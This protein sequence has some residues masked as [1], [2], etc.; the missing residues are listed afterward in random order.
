MTFVGICKDLANDGKGIVEYENKIVLVDNLLVGEK[1]EIEIYNE[2]SRCSY[3]KVVKLITKSKDRKETLCPNY[4]KCGGCQ[5]MHLDYEKQ[6][7]FK[8]EQI[9]RAYKRIANI[10]VDVLEP[11]F[12]NEFGYRNKIELPV[13]DNKIGFYKN[14]TKQIV[15]IINCKLVDNKTNDVIR[16]ISSIIKITKPDIKHIVIKRSFKL[17][18]TMLIVVSKEKEFLRKEEF[19]EKIINQIPYLTTLIHNINKNKHLTLS[20]KNVTIFGK[21]YIEDEIL[22]TKFIVS[23][24]SFYQV[25]AF[26]TET[27]YA[28]AIEQAKISK[29]DVVLDA[30]CGVGTIGILASK[31]AK[32]VY[33]VEINIE[34][35]KDARK[36]AKLNKIDN[37]RFVCNDAKKFLKSEA[38]DANILILDPP[39]AGSD[40]EFLD[41][42]IER[43]FPKIVYISCD[44]QTQ[45]RDLKRL[46][47]YYEIKKVQPVEMFPNTY[48]VET[49]VLLCLKDA[50]K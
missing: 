13:V 20:N 19:F 1:A 37:I 27:L 44:Y 29:K 32:K 6:L 17:D 7:E 8:K 47:P 14:G 11:L 38:K 30:Y 28:T 9:K 3:G 24:S 34:A 10:D 5:L 21:G 18:Q 23:A 33:G 15:P 42:V 41:L 39:R 40:K 22:N 35:I 26:Q 50:K 49:I 12:A 31:Y 43:K 2:L 4:K 45:A 16:I 25:N 36:N 48:H 46:E